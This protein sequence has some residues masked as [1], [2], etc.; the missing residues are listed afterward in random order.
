MKPGLPSLERPWKESPKTASR[1]HMSID[2]NAIRKM[3]SCVLMFFLCCG[4]TI[5]CPG[6]SGSTAVASQSR[7]SFGEELR[8]P[9]GK[10]IHIFYVHGIGS[11]GPKDRDS[12]ALRKSLCDYLR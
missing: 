12:R 9:G 6:Q 11:D 10:E 5:S 4:A 8:H 1:E 2:S 7:D 3:L